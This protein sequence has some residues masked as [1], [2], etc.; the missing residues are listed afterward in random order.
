MKT[1]TD[2]A[3]RIWSIDI[4]VD[5]IRRVQ[6]LCNINLADLTA[7]GSGD[8][9]LLT[10]L[11]TDIVLLCDVIF[12]LVQPQAERQGVTDVDF[13]RSLGGEGIAQAHDA[14]WEELRDF[15]QK[16]RRHDQA[17]AIDKQIDLVK[18]TVAAVDQRINDIDPRKL[19][20][21]ALTSMP[22]GSASSSRASSVS[23]PVPES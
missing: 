18:A 23:I 8:Q 21:E 14:F 4:T 5:A 3:G 6:G 17:R 20:D 16:L 10:R 7:S 13:G 22:L 9:P 19:V 1:F 12:S 2:V 11:E 15:F